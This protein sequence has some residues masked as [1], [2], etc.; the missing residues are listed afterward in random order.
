LE[1]WMLL[2]VIAVGPT[3]MC[4][5]VFFFASPVCL[6]LLGLSGSTSSKLSSALCV[7]SGGFNW[8]D[9]FAVAFSLLLLLLVITASARYY[10]IGP[11]IVGFFIHCC[12]T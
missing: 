6:L 7:V 2:F 4:H 12:D 8:K 3:R 9:D 11:W 1:R 5:M 10:G